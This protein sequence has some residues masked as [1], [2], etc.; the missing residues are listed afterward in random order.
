M[1][2]DDQQLK[3]TF[4]VSVQ[5]NIVFVEI[6]SHEQEPENYIRATELACQICF[7]LFARN[8][9]KIYNFLVEI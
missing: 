4:K 8:P 5:D 1:L 7:D 6:L 2:K 9:D 3:E